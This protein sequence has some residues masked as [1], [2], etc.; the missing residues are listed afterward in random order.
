VVKDLVLSPRMRWEPSK[1]ALIIMDM[2]KEHWCVGATARVA[3]L[4]P[5]MNEATY[6]LRKMGL[7]VIHHPSRGMD[8]YEGTPMRQRVQKVPPIEGCIPYVDIRQSDESREGKFPIDD[9]DGGCD[10]AP[11][12]VRAERE[13]YRSYHQVES[14]TLEED[15]AVADGIEAYFLMRERGITNMFIMGVHANM[16]ILNRPVGIRQMV[17]LGMRVC[18]IRDLTDTMYNHRMWPYV[19]HFHGTNIVID[20]IERHWCPTVTSADFIGGEP[21]HFAQEDV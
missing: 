16:C 20:H 8:H 3:E 11:Q 14:I 6:A 13:A 19:S 21:F 7:L 17:D 5:H 4:A 18:L 9:S 1:T 15:D 12:C 2:W 10:C